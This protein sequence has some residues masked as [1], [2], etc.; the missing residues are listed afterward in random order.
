MS[1]SRLDAT[2]L[3]Q[4]LR[5]GTLSVQEVVL[6]RLN[7]IHQS[8]P[9]LGAFL[10]LEQDAALARAT[11]MD[12]RR[13]RGDRL[14]ALF[15]VPVAI[16]ANLCRAGAVTSCGSRI[17]ESWEAPYTA[18]TVE[19]LLAADA[20]VL[21]STNMDEFG[22]GSST[23][24]SA[25]GP[26]RNPW[27]ASST[28]GGSS[29]GSAAAVAAGLVPLALGSDTGGSIRQPASYCGV[30]GFKPSY[31]RLSRYGLVAFASSLDQVAPICT[32]VRDLE[33][34]MQVL[35]G[36][37]PLD[38][39]CAPL[40][41][42]T[43]LA[44]RDHLPGLRIGV[45]PQ[46]FPAGVAPR[47]K[48]AVDQAIRH[49]ESLGANIVGVD[50]PHLDL[51]L[52]CYYVVA[53]SEASSNLSRH[54][55]VRFGTRIDGDGSLDGM[56]S[57]TRG[58]GFGAEV[59]RRILLGTFALSAGYA[60]EW[61]G[62]ALRVRRL[63]AQDFERAFEACDIL[64]APTAPGAAFGLGERNHDPLAMYAADTL[65]VPASL[66]GLPAVS[67]PCGFTSEQGATLPLGLQ[68][69]GPPL[70]DA[71]VLAT[72]RTFEESTD[73]R[74]SPTAGEATV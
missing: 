13:E 10:E 7:R 72:A 32:S 73:F 19:R 70:A 46:Y 41:P 35:S 34:A 6:A 14:G 21:G 2:A 71:E 56:F 3:A 16:K 68:L 29:G 52:P 50:L 25:F 44:P 20:I 28:P 57:S 24:N 37:D 31:G 17:L 59:A 61:F 39:T 49:L 18:T 64:V 66:A 45:A 53:M 12:R 55:G 51:A 62:R 1:S 22:M 9:E 15:G 23:E 27:D 33:L 54:D 11:D 42:L 74:R 67:I 30:A 8:D 58:R 48:E 5:E 26:T 40:P 43:P 63:I 65:T 60:D 69:I 36:G 38:S 4:T 47:M